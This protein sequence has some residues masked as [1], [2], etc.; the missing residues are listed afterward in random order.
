[1]YELNARSEEEEQELS[2]YMKS[3]VA[4]LN[5][6]DINVDD[7]NPEEEDYDNGP[8]DLFDDEELM[9]SDK[10]LKDPKGGLTAAGRAYFNRTTGSKLKPG[11]RGAA[12]TPE[13]MRRKGSFLTRFF[14]NPSGPMVNDKGEP[15]RLALSAH[16]WGEPVPKNMDD[17]K[18]LAQKGRRLLERYQE[19]KKGDKPDHPFRGNQHTKGKATGAKS[20]APKTQKEQEGAVKRF[21]SSAN[22]KQLNAYIE[23]VRTAGGITTAMGYNSDLKYAQ[24]IHNL[25]LEA[26]RNA[27]YKGGIQKGDKPN[28]PFRGNQYTG[29]GAK[30]APKKPNIKPSAPKVLKSRL[31]ISGKR[32]EA[33]A[34][35]V[36][37]YMMAPAKRFKDPNW[38]RYATARVNQMTSGKP[39]PSGMSKKYNMT[40]EDVIRCE[41]VLSRIFASGRSK[42]GI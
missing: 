30:T 21:M 14:T 12:D 18:K 15:T 7:W 25:G 22:D 5:E 10:P 1:M 8:V 29:R 20:K 40:R 31:T 11:V 35:K 33:K 39:R 36:R 24:T 6:E 17:A 37:D 41:M 26:A 9:K 27:G 19:T 28:H 42:F 32:A 2:Q 38:R 4:D 13:K 34:Q 16:A 23:A 3:L